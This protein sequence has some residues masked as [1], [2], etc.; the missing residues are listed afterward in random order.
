LSKAKAVSDQEIPET[1]RRQQP[2]RVRLGTPL[3]TLIFK[4]SCA[5]SDS[6]EINEEDKVEGQNCIG[7]SK[8][9]R[10]ERKR[11]I[12]QNSTEIKLDD[13]EDKAVLG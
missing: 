9:S 6:T 13:A 3:K 4:R 1:E 7:E 11:R 5:E 10:K 2:Y 8:P 12:G